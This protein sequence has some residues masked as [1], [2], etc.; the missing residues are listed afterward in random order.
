[1]ATK[2][3]PTP[4]TDLRNRL[5]HPVV[6]VDG[7]MVEFFPV[8]FD[9]LKQVGGGDMVDQMW[10]T[11]TKQNRNWHKIDAAERRRYGVMRPAFWAAP[12]ENTT[13]RATAMLPRLMHERLP[14]MGIDYSVV[15]PTVGFLLPDLP[16]EDVRKAACRAQ[17]L[18]AADIFSGTQDR[19]T[20]AAVIPCH[21]PEE[22]IAELDFTLDELGLKVPMF[23][24]LVR[25]PLEPVSELDPD[26]ARYAFWVDTLALDSLYD[27]DPVWQKCMDLKV[28]V[29]AHAVAQGIGMRRSISNYMY[30]QTGHF[31][32]AAHAF[33][34]SLFFGGVTKRFPN[35]N[36]AFLECGVAWAACLVCDLVERWEKRNKHAVQ[37]FNPERLDLKTFDALMERY[38]GDI[39]SDQK[40]SAGLLRNPETDIDD[41][42]ATGIETMQDLHDRLVPNFYYGC[43]ADDR[44]NYTAFKAD[45]LPFGAKLNALFSSDFGHWDVTD[46]SQIL[47][48][49]YKLVDDGI[50][51]EDDFR[52]FVF[53]N[54]VKL[55]AGMNPRFFEGTAVETEAAKVVAALPSPQAA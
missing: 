11:F 10:S 50:M 32:D 18:M 20:P 7:H 2:T 44:M 33:A 4:S 16:Q 13:D 8:F 6:D 22:A 43:E 9:Y 31:A 30:N 48:E 37:Q 12:S 34:K 55:L 5:D 38:G 54:P 1:M 19:L 15:Y 39:F 46:M 49:A 23:A 51:T 35:L 14:E 29:T 40:I 36:F 28:P 45:A 24:N 41:F 27:Y 3:L 47:V 21:T 53:T 17:N 26:L 52:D 25:R 42:A